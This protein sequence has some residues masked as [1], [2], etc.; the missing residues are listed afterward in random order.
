MHCS[1]SSRPI[2]D[3]ESIDVVLGILISEGKIVKDRECFKL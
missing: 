3:S 2:F 1:T